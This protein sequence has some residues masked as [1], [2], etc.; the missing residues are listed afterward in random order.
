M[1]TSL[2]FLP[3]LLGLLLGLSTLSQAQTANLWTGQTDSNWHNPANWSLGLVPNACH[4]VIIQ[5]ATSAPALQGDVQ[6]HELYLLDGASVLTND[7]DIYLGLGLP[8]TVVA[9]GATLPCADGPVF[10]LTAT[11]TGPDTTAYHYLWIGPAGD[12]LQTI[13]QTVATDTLFINSPQTGVRRDTAGIVV[14]FQ[15]GFSVAPGADYLAVISQAQRATTLTASRSGIYTLIVTDPATGCSVQ[16]TALLRREGAPTLAVTPPA[17]LSCLNESVTLRATASLTGGSPGS[18]LY[19]WAGAPAT[20]LGSTQAVSQPG[21]YVITVT[22][23]NNL[24]STVDTVEVITNQTL[25]QATLAGG[26]LS[27]DPAQPLVLRLSGQEPV[28]ASVLWASGATTDSLAVSQPGSYT[29]TVRHPVSG[30]TLTLTAEV[31]A[32]PL[33]AVA[34]GCALPPLPAGGGLTYE[35]W[36]GQPGSQVSDLNLA[37]APDT[38]GVLTSLEA[39]SLG[40]SNYGVRLRGYVVPPTGGTYTFWLAAHAD[41]ELW[42]STDEDPLHKVKIAHQTGPVGARQYGAT[43]SQRSAPVTLAC[44]QRYYLEVLHKQGSGSDHLSVSWQIPGQLWDTLPVPGAYLTPFATCALAIEGDST[45]LYLGQT[46]ALHLERPGGLTEPV[47]WSSSYAHYVSSLTATDST[48]SRSGVDTVYVRPG[49]AGTYTYAVRSSTDASCWAEYRLRVIDQACACEDCDLPAVKET[50]YPSLDGSQPLSGSHSYVAESLYRTADGSSVSQTVT[51]LDGLGRPVQRVQVQAGGYGPGGAAPTDLVQPIVYDALGRQPREYLPY[52]GASS[53]GQFAAGAVAAQASYYGS[54]LGKSGAAYAQLQYEASPLNR[55][56]ARTAP[57]SSQPVT[58]RYRTNRAG[59]LFRLQVDFST[60][61]LRVSTYAAGSLRVVE[62]TDE[63][64]RPTTE[65]RDLF[66]RVVGQDVGGLRTHYGY[67]ARGQLRCVVPPGAVQLLSDGASL[68]PFAGDLLFAY[69]YDAEGRLT[70]KKVPGSGSST[71]TYT[72]RDLLD[73]STDAK[74][75]VLSYTYDTLN[76][77]V[78]VSLNGQEITHHYYDTYPSDDFEASHA[79]GQAR[80]TNTTGLATATDQRVLGSST[81][82][83]TS[84]YY[85]AEGRV[86]QLS[87]QNHKGSVDRSSLKLD[88]SGQVLEERQTTRGL[89]LLTRRSYDR[90]GRAKAICQQVYDEQT[91]EA[92]KYWEPVGRYAYNG[93]GEL[94]GKTLGCGIQRVDYAYNLRGWLTR[95]NDPAQLAAGK[96]FF[97]M[98]LTYDAVGNISGWQYRS[99]QRTGPYTEAFSVTAKE[100]YQYGFTYDNLYR[101]KTAGLTK[102][103][104]PVYA[105]GGTDNGAMDYDA[106]GNITSLR[107]S[108]QGSVVDELSYVYTTGSNQLAS[109][110]DGGTN[111]STPNE[112]FG[113]NASYGYDA[114]GNLISDSGKGISSISYN[115][116]NLPQAVTQGSQTIGYTYEAGGQKLKADFGSGKVYD[117]V[118][119]L[120]YVNDSLEFIPTA[121]GRILPPGRAVNPGDTVTNKFYRYEY[122]LKDHLGNLRVACRCEE[123]PNATMPSE[124]YVPIVV[125][126]NHYDPWGLSLPLDTLIGSPADRFTYNGK[127]KQGE[128]GWLDYGARMYDAQLGRWGVIDPMAEKYYSFSLYN[129]SLNDPILLNDI[130]GRDIDVSRFNS[131]EEQ[132]ILRKFLT[133]KEGYSFFAQ[134]ANKGDKVAG[135]IFKAT[136]SHAKDLLVIQSTDHVHMVYDNGQTQT[137]ER[138]N[139]AENTDRPGSNY[140]KDLQYADKNTDA[141]KGIIHLIRINKGQDDVFKLHTLSH[142]SFVHV[143]EDI[144]RLSTLQSDGSIRPGTMKYIDQLRAIGESAISDHNKLGQGRISSYRNISAQLDKLNN[145]KVYT[146]LYN[147]DVRNHGKR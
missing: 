98:S 51:Y 79:F 87:S 86:I 62:T 146:E 75:Q 143:Q 29:V 4:D 131:K 126:E 48:D 128:L 85:D 107:R 23:P 113:S 115:Y 110:A 127:E 101:L 147:K 18:P 108:F 96:D 102:A 37:V 67:D 39:P 45:A 2:R 6:L 119:G 16:D 103:G 91:P 12:T 40:Q 10:P 21:S 93:I 133:T 11:V 17:P 72:S 54:T 137:F 66:D 99:A 55:V 28:T 89:T 78:T 50:D 53:G 83:R 60:E 136:G 114:N 124:A 42:L 95:M 121:E 84:T 90:G 56:V 25:P 76:R 111:P 35:R 43:P 68:D 118:A 130:D 71:M 22:D 129:Y 144:N 116:L 97:G 88:F 59:E 49:A 32:N 61:P 7:Y 139:P 134:F 142:E 30:C 26:M 80:K 132:E 141:S 20:V 34:E 9:H 38:V 70:A 112:F 94:T 92:G 8:F 117:Y 15:A 109:V 3:L 122:Q 140:G 33:C 41:A 1:P 63:A 31:T 44:G 14:F 73:T 104:A 69:Q 47:A 57:G 145:T 19:S 13:D 82:L 5:G 120:V 106:N 138:K 46:R 100:L 36:E 123:K 27:C 135:V 125:Q 52:A 65:Y 64:G 105:L 74:G 77:A 81:L 24:C 58:Y